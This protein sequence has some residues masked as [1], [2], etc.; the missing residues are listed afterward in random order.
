MRIT[1][2]NLVTRAKQVLENLTRTMNELVQENE[3]LQKKRAPERVVLLEAKNNE[4]KGTVDRM[5]V[6]LAQKEEEVETLKEQLEQAQKQ[7][8][9]F[10][11]EMTK[12][13]KD[14][15]AQ[16][17]QLQQAEEQNEF[18]AAELSKQQEEVA[19]L[20]EQLQQAQDANK[21]L[22]VQLKKRSTPSPVPQQS[23]EGLVKVLERRVK[24]LEAE[25]EQKDK[26][27][28]EMRE[29]LA[30]AQKARAQMERQVVQLEKE[31][32]DKDEDVKKAKEQLQQAQNE[33]KQ[34]KRRSGQVK[35]PIPQ[36]IPF[37]V[38]AENQKLREENEEL[39]EHLR[40]LEG[41]VSQV[42]RALVDTGSQVEEVL[43]RSQDATPPR[44][45]YPQR[46]RTRSGK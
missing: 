37:T 33:N 20:K 38:L 35:T 13:D 1:D 23:H 18:L 28:Q 43:P 39:K 30:Q 46:W 3:R 36:P 19:T 17:E 24:L 9:L 22:V 16:R 29:Q 8:S 31:L 6:V 7:N 32:G 45:P 2:P 40:E 15:A 34:L 4:L 11:A 25:G 12:R 27:L 10:A 41:R 14:A 42:K 26:Q 21:K 5:H 44:T